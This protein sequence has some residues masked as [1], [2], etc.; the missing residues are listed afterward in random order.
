MRDRDMYLYMLWNV[1]NLKIM[2][3]IN[4][5]TIINI[6]NITGN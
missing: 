3:R 6:V 2:G 1:V 4:M 5:Q